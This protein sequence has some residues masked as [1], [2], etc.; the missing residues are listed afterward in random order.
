MIREFCDHCNKEII[1]ESESN[2]IWNVINDV[3]YIPDEVMLCEKCSDE[4]LKMIRNFING[5]ED[6]NETMDKTGKDI[7]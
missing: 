4:L 2:E 3:G 1:D 5:K 7:H 6:E